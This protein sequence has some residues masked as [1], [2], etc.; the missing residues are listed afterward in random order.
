LYKIKG[1]TVLNLGS[2]I[3]GVIIAIIFIWALRTTIKDNTAG[4]AG[5]CSSCH[6]GC[7]SSS[8]GEVPNWVKEYRKDHP[9]KV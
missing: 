1:G 2:I 5:D 9:K 4:C 6:S 7:S 8:K 3:V